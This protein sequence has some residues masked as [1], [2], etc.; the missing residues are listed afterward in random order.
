[1]PADNDRETAFFALADM[2]RNVLDSQRTA[3]VQRQRTVATH[4]AQQKQTS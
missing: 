3:A 4:L 2:A 1:M